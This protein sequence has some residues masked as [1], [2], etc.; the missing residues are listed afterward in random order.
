M[1]N[2]KGTMSKVRRMIDALKQVEE[3]AVQE[4]FEG[5]SVT[6]NEINA[7]AVN[8]GRAR[9]AAQNVEGS[10]KIMVPNI[11]VPARQPVDSGDE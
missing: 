1:N 10:L 3:L 11:D 2:I 8:V 9:A 5:T 6:F 7:I 4:T